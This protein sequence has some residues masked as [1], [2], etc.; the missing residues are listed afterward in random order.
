LDW[1]IKEY[2]VDYVIHGDDPCIVDGKDVYGHVKEMGMFRSIP[3]T[4]GVS[5][6]EIIGRM[7][8]MTK[9]HH[10]RERSNSDVAAG[11]P[12]LEAFPESEN[13]GYHRDSKFLTTSKM[14]YEF[15]QPLR[16]I[17]PGMKVVYV[18]G[19]W[20]MFHSGHAA[21]LR[22]A[23]KLGDFLLVGIYNDNILNSHRGGNYPILNLNE[24]TLNVLQCKYVDDVII[25]PPWA[26]TEEM[27]AQCKISLVVRG[28]KN[29]SESS[30]KEQ[31]HLYFDC[32]IQ[33]NIFRVIK[34][35]SDLSVLEI[36]RRVQANR[37]RLNAKIK[38][39]KKAETAFYKEKHGLSD[40]Y[41]FGT[42]TDG[43]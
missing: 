18:A 8:V 2:N 27:V 26:I 16:S 29:E 31:D 30:I 40:N 9:D 34:S 28:T 13:Q 6:T 4:E 22:E 37:E 21:L 1:V 39:K 17:K 19:G 12:V 42:G 25:D 20:D 14:I 43:N 33:K 32:A 36:V 24:R 5:T 35:T 23:K 38:R 7:L 3:R 11:T 10:V 15:S 41:K